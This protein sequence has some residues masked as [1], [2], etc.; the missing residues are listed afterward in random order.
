MSAKIGRLKFV[1]GRSRHDVRVLDP[2]TGQDLTELLHITKF[3]IRFDARDG[4]PIAEVEM[5]NIGLQFELE[6][7]VEVE[8]TTAYK[9]LERE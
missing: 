5:M 8:T 6:A 7:D 4:Y 2:E 3:V 1:G 9:R